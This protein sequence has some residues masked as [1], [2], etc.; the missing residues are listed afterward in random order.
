[1]LFQA[2]GDLAELLVNLRHDLLQFK[3]RN[4][5]ADAGHHIFSLRVHQEFAIKLL[6][7]D[8]RITRE[9]NAGTAGLAKIPEYHCLHI[10]GGSE[11]V[12]DIVNAPVSL[13]A[14]VVPGP[15]DGISSHDEL[16]ARVLRKLPPGVLLDSFLVF[17]NHFLQSPGIELRVELS[18]LLFLL[19]VE[20]FVE[21]E[22]GNL[23]KDR[24]STRLNSSH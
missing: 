20:D 15:E 8:C 21:S 3:N 19:F 1:M 12:I 16:F 13:R 6:R 18:L 2:S 9:A 11:H 5:R 14:L 17:L 10:D 24:K 7:A 22:F 4:R 23:K